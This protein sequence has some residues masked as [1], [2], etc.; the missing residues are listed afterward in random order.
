MGNIE[1]AKKVIRDQM[2]VK[3]EIRGDS[4]RMVS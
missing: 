3:M 4:I 2:E 1:L